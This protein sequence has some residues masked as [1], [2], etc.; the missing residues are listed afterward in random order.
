MSNVYQKNISA[1]IQKNP[2]LARRITDYVIKDVPQL[3]NEN[4]FYNLVYKNTRLHNPANPLGE[5]QEIFARAEN[6]PVTIHLIYGLGLGYLFQVAS[7][8]SI[9][10]VILYEPD[11]NILKIA[12]T[13]VDFSKDIEKN[14][15]FIADN[16]DLLGEYIHKKS[17][18][19]NTPLM[20]TTRAYRELN[21]ET[22]DEMVENIQRMIGSFNLDLKY[23]QEKFYPLTRSIIRNI[24]Q[25]LNEIPLTAIKDVF[26]GKT[27]VVVSAGPTLDRN[28]ETLKKYRDNII[29]IVVGTAMKTL[30]KHNITPDF[31]CIIE[32][33]DSSKQIAGLDLSE[34][35]FIT[36]PYSN[37]NLRNFKFKQIYSHISQNMPV[38]SIW[39]SL[40][41]QNINE[42]LSKGTVSYTALNTA[43]IL[44]CS[45]IVMVGQD[46]AYIE[47]QC[48]SKDSAYK[49]LECRYNKDNNRWEITAKNFE[50]FANSLS[51]SPDEEKRKKAAE[52]R[53]RNLNNS[54]YYVKGIKGDKIPTES[55]Y[56][57]FIKPLT[58][59]AEMFNDRE[60]INTSMEGAQIDGYKNMPLEEALKDTQPIETR[61][62]K[63]DYKLD[64]TSLKTNIT[65]EI[66]NLKKTKEDVLNGEK[67]V[68]TLNNDLKRYKAPTVEVLKDLKK[69]SQLFLNLSTS[70]AGTL[71]DFITA[72]EKIDID[73]EM[74]MTGN[75]TIETLT[76]LIAKFSNY[77]NNAEKKIDR[78][79]QL[80]SNTLEKL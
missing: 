72:S 46:L 23:T 66:S 15:V 76:T 10:T 13:L 48:Y 44:G 29:L 45:K 12:F 63:S 39:S 42:Y 52:N 22:F 59:F 7:A 55:V 6:T 53:L 40:T 74:K 2:V 36:E 67:A 25:L 26:K 64:L 4:G 56:A 27:A 20:L 35:N 47:G 8:N 58:E 24:P 57:A 49:D 41:A 43:R 69:V 3:V 34:V 37:P 65:T 33:Y 11:L 68:K 79:I 30:A 60:Y 38:N 1:L 17:N 78:V 70:K 5:A 16:I 61:E 21:N 54:L 73:Y 28:I 14:N 71:F 75:F 62:I 31:L 19:K 18:T 50:E 32:A 77:F 80:L 51:N 9:G